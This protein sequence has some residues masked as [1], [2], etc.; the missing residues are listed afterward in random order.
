MIDH[1]NPEIYRFEFFGAEVII[2]C[3]LMVECGAGSTWI[4]DHRVAVYQWMFDEYQWMCMLQVVIDMLQA[5]YLVSCY[6]D[7]QK[8]IPKAYQSI[9]AA[10]IRLCSLS[11]FSRQIKFEMKTRSKA[12]HHFCHLHKAIRV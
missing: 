5:L 1:E 3:G 2:Y 4:Q 7:G 11:A 9:F 6:I 12:M 8:V 10:R